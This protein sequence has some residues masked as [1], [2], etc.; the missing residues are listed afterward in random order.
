[1]G[2]ISHLN[3]ST[4]F[5]LINLEAN[6]KVTG[7]VG[8]NGI[9]PETLLPK[10]NENTVKNVRIKFF[11]CS[12]WA[13][14]YVTSFSVSWLV[15]A[16]IQTANNVAVLLPCL[17]VINPCDIKKKRIIE[18][19]PTKWKCSKEVKVDNAGSE[20]QIKHKWS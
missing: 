6:T 10:S 20:I 8:K 1:M 9:P 14:N 4:T 16:H 13:V 2:L 5:Y 3:L 17:A 15:T 19:W 12:L 18:N 11:W 7:D